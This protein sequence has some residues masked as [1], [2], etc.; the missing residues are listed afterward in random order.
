MYKGG[1]LK[2]QK[3]KYRDKILKQYAKEPIFKGKEQYFR[4]GVI[5]DKIIRDNRILFEQKY[6]DYY[7]QK[8]VSNS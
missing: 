4:N 1:K 6:D 8:R 5:K 2:L 7:K 3:R